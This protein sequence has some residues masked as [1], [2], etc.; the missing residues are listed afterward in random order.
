NVEWFGKALAR[1]VYISTVFLGYRKVPHF[2][3]A[4][5]KRVPGKEQY[6]VLRASIDAQTL[7]QF[8][9]TI[10]TEASDDIFIIDYDGVLQTTSQFYGDI[11]TEYP[12]DLRPKHGTILVREKSDDGMKTVEALADLEGTPWVLVLVKQGY[13]YGKSWSSFRNQLFLILG[14]SGIIG[15]LVIVRTTMLLTNRIA[16]ADEKR[17][18][19]LAEAEH[20][21]KLA[22]V[23]RL[24]AGVAHEINNPLAIINQKAGL[25][26]DL[27]QMI[28]EFPQ[29]EKVGRQ[30]DG[31]LDAVN[32]CKIVTHRLLG[33]ARRMDV[34]LEEIEINELIKEVLGFL[35]REALY[36]RIRLDLALQEGIPHIRSDRGQLQ[37]I[38]LNIINN[39]I[40]VV[41]ENGVIAISTRQKMDQTIEVAITDN[42]PGIPADIMKHIFEPFFTTKEAG[43]GTG[44]GLS[45]T[46]GLVKKLGGSI[47]VKS[48]VGVGTTFI[49]EIPIS[50]RNGEQEQK[51]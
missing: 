4:V 16:V 20:T 39:A 22:S 37:Q 34:S 29:K 32:R 42:G 28:E 43:K 15:L 10:D 9:D 6:W 25:I 33:F 14:L 48:T 26:K 35:D 17:E 40:D 1:R 12:L 46:Y 49:V 50:G 30:I 13:A 18:A 3:I 2:V 21:S 24:A 11:K 38:F 36:R 23:G 41:E 45:I 7:E 8:V 27:L 47:Q 51:K 44:L 19:I 5:S 31:I